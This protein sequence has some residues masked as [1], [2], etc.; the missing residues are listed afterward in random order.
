MLE[1]TSSVSSSAPAQLSSLSSRTARLLNRRFSSL[2][3]FSALI[4]GLAQPLSAQGFDWQTLAGSTRGPGSQ[5]GT[6]A[7]TRISGL[8]GVVADAAGNLYFTDAANHTIRKLSAAGISSTIAGM[9]GQAGSDDGTGEAARFM[10]P[11]GIAINSEGVLFVADTANQ[12]IRRISVTGEVTTLAGQPGITGTSD[13]PGAEAKF[14]YPQGIAVGP[15]DV[16]YIADTYNHAI[17]K[18]SADGVVSTFAGKSGEMGAADGTAGNARFLS[19]IGLLFT[20]DGFLQVADTGNCTL[21]R[22]SPQG[23]VTTTAGQPGVFSFADGVGTAALFSDP[24]GITLDA[25]GNLIV[26]EPSNSLLRRVTPDGAVTTLTGTLGAVGLVNGPPGI[27]RFSY[28]QGVAFNPV[29]GLI[30]VADVGNEALRNVTAAGLTTTLV[31]G[32]RQPGATEGVGTAARFRSPVAITALPDGSFAV[33]DSGNRTIRKLT[34]AGQTSLLAGLT[35]VGGAIDGNLTVA[36]F[37]MPRGIT[38]DASGTLF[39][40][41]TGNQVIRKI[42]TNGQV[43]TIAGLPGGKSDVNR[44][45]EAAGVVVDRDGN[46]YCTDSNQIRRIS[47]GGGALHVAG[48]IRKL[49]FTPP[50]KYLLFWRNTFNGTTG[51]GIGSDAAIQQAHGPSIDAAGNVY[52]ADGGFHT[53]RKCTPS[54]VVTTLAG[55]AKNPGSADGTGAA[56]RFFSPSGV[57]VAPDG[58]VYV[59]DEGNHVIRKISPA[60]V[61]TTIGGRVGYAGTGHGIGSQTAFASPGGLMLDPATGAVLVADTTN[62]RIVRGVAIHAPQL[63]VEAAGGRHLVDDTTTEDFGAIAPGT[64]SAERTLVLHNVGNQPLELQSAVLEFGELSGFQIEGLSEPGAVAPN[65]SLTLRV[66]FAP[67]SL[68]HQLAR[69]V[70]RSNDPTHPAFAL[71]L[72]G[73]GNSTPTFVGYSAT[74]VAGQAISLDPIK[75]LAKATDADA[76][77]LL[78]ITGVDAVSSRGAAVRLVNGA[79]VYTP[80]PT[81]S[82]ADTFF[83][84]IR[85]A[86]GSEVKGKV[87]LNIVASSIANNTLQT[88]PP[89]ITRSTDGQVSLTFRGIPGRSY[90]IQRSIDLRNWPTVATVIASDTGTIEWQDP[91]PPGPT[92]YYRLANR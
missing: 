46:V 62:H 24:T 8:S 14:N 70:I 4:G 23:V 34:A 36:T 16:V 54:G 61:V 28:P 85:D 80:G 52:F 9:P 38:A 88:N 37:G 15:G 11:A 91:T 77:D 86:R 1:A 40:G 64:R 32:P 55:L 6:L 27:A 5:D 76:G 3:F 63:V 65:A 67:P 79:V 7:E 57:A 59:A 12:L 56:A 21:R 20:N 83:I 89:I 68:G 45:L 82:G 58:T 33:A 78:T 44:F 42:T 72:S 50:D 26:T 81:L 73:L 66:S 22:V 60:G 87:S 75:L 71:D 92:S 48:P 47:P 74:T 53:I 13:G 49:Q 25:D 43:S 2:L 41:D 69:L 30:A 39:V 19:P 90:L 35:G 18:I 29:T 51:D 31:G 17:R 84:T 10:G